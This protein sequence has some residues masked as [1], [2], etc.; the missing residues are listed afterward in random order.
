MSF[1][2]GGLIPKSC[3]HKMNM[4]SSTEAEIIGA[5]D[6]LPNVIW[7]K[8]FMETQGHKIVEN[9]FEQDNES[10]VKL[11]RNGRALAGPKSRHLDIRYFWSKDRTKANTI[12]IRHC[13]TLKMHASGFFTK[14]LQ[15]ALFTKF[16]DVILGYKHVDSL[17]LDSTPGPEERVG[18]VQAGSNGAD[19]L[20]ADGHEEGKVQMDN[21]VTWA[22][23]V[24]PRGQERTRANKTS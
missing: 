21:R 6:Y 10:A 17:D 2:L 7:A 24:A 14:P 15:G 5:S 8:M 4:K 18:S 22:D 3:K 11:E 16:R 1:G 19:G 23:V 13:S 9:W 12:R 20:L